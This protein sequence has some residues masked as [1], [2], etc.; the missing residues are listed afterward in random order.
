MRAHQGLITAIIP[1]ID[2]VAMRKATMCP[3][4]KF[5]INLLLNMPEAS[6]NFV[7]FAIGCS[8]SSGRPCKSAFFLHR[9][10]LMAGLTTLCFG[11]TETLPMSVDEEEQVV[12]VKASLGIWALRLNERISTRA[13]TRNP[14]NPA[15]HLFMS[16]GPMALKISVLRRTLY[17][18]RWT[19]AT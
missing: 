11:S 5:R 18:S 14:R 3:F 8:S 12:V 7:N 19:T 6:C 9:R 4:D 10:I 13:R 16:T 2:V 17:R 15:N 1:R